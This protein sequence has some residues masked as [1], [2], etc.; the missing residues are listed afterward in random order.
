MTISTYVIEMMIDNLTKISD[1]LE[2]MV[3]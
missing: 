1:Y 2:N 3:S